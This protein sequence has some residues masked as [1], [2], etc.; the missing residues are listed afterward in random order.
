MLLMPTMITLV[1][2]TAI[3]S[4][5][6][7][8]SSSYPFLTDLGFFTRGSSVPNQPAGVFWAIVASLLIICQTVILFR[9]FFSPLVSLLN[10]CLKLFFSVS[11]VGWPI[12]FFD[13]YFPVLGSGFGLGALGIFQGLSVCS[14]L[15]CSLK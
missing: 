9:E 2:W 10:F 6:L 13:H 12:A 5:K 8:I 7:C 14:L 3:T 15:F 11:E 4:S 1:W